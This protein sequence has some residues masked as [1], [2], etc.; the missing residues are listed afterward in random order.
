MEAAAAGAEDQ[1]AVGV[2][3]GAVTWADGEAATKLEDGEEVGAAGAKVGEDT[4]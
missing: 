4:S 2:E 3:A 1:E